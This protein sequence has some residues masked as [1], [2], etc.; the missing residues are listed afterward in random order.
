MTKAVTTPRGH[1]VRDAQGVRLEFVRTFDEAVED[2]W[3][4]LTEPDRVARWFGRWTGDPSSGSVEMTM[5]EEVEGLPQ[6]V[7]IVVCEPP[8]RLVVDVPGPDGTWHLSA[9]VQD[10]D[11]RTALSFVHH[12]A[13]PYDASSIGP[14]W[15]FY[16]DR[17]GAVVVGGPLPD[18]WEDYYPALQDAYAKDPRL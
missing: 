11:G 3:A 10:R 13:E 5:T 7:T 16:L 12:L 1:L 2:V 9:T 6:T 18:S 17:L 15:H 14:G 4:A 8:N